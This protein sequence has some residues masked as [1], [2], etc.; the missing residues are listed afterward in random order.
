V[1]HAGLQ[2]IVGL[3]AGLSRRPLLIAIDGPGGSGKSTLAQ[4]LGRRLPGAVVVQG[5]D[6][7]RD[8]PAADREQLD[9]A[10]GYEQYFDWQRLRREVLLPVR[11]G[12]PVLR[13]Q[14]YDWEGA[15]MG[16]WVEVRMPA[17]VVVEG[18]YTLR[19]ALADLVDLTV[20]VATGET[21]RLE[22]QRLRGENTD[23]WIRRWMAAEDHYLRTERPDLRAEVL[24][25]GE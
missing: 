3:A 24:V 4:E 13:Y 1:D 14:R 16:A 18:V 10:A 9:A 20:F 22:R 23:G 19:P 5:D 12:L 15:R 2:R 6:F 8:V 21:T 11:E 25:R 17:I 7:Y